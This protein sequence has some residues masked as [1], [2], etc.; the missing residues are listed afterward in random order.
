MTTGTRARA[1]FVLGL[2]AA[3]AAPLQGQWTLSGGIRASRFSGGAIEVSTESS[4][5]PYRP[6]VFGFG[7]ERD[8]RRV[9]MGLRVYY[10]SSSLALEATDA[11]SA[12]KDALTIYGAEPEL[13]LRLARV[14]Q[15]G[16]FRLYGGPLLEFW[17]LGGAVT[18]TR[19]GI[20]A[21]LGLEVPFGGR[22]SGA[23]RAGAAVTPSSPF[24]KE[25]LDAAFAP[26]ALWRRE[27]E[28]SLRYRL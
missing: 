2:L 20:S 18:R 11:V 12:V 14:G 24:T 21:D 3:A 27:I 7:L 8:G 10:T 19:L 26:R 4:L 17:D 28:G 5:S 15:D 6:T 25:D 23:V 1:A 13:S 16:V 9:G 22:W